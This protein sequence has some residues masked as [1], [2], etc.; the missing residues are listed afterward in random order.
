MGFFDIPASK[1]ALC[2][3]LGE[4]EEEEGNA[5]TEEGEEEEVSVTYI[6]AVFFTTINCHIEFRGPEPE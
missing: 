4:E 5:K 3:F 6:S 2:S 1:F